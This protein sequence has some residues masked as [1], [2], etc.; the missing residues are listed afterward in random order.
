MEITGHTDVALRVREQKANELV[1]FSGHCDP[2]S[3]NPS[4]RVWAFTRYPFWYDI[5]SILNSP[6]TK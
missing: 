1:G 2:K 4:Q 3:T 5:F 6:F